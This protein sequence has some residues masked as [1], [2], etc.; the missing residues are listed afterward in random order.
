MAKRT[1]QTFK[2]HL[3]YDGNKVNEEKA[4]AVLK[5]IGI[6]AQSEIGETPLIVAAYLGRANILKMLIEQVDDIDYK[7]PG[8]ITESALLMACN[9]RPLECIQ[10]LV[11]AGA[12][13]EQEDSLG[14]TPLSMVFTNAFSDPIP[15][16]TY[17]VSKGSKITARV[18]EIG[19][20]WNEEKF[21]EFLKTVQ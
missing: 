7:V 16:A 6:N 2:K 18:I 1:L 15:S 5:E 20:S 4:L 21:N 3:G 10:L 17:L 14:L 12:S 8:A 11:E 19:R 9:Q 13:L